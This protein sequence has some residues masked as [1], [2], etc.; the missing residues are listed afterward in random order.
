MC[1]GHQLASARRPGR[2]GALL[3]LLA[4]ASLALGAPAA[5]GEKVEEAIRSVFRDYRKAVLDGQGRRAAS[6]LSAETIDYYRRLQQQALFG[7][8]ETIRALPVIER[9]QVFF[10]RAHVPREDL[11]RMSGE[12]V[13][14]YAVGKGWVSQQQIARTDLGAVEIDGD[15]ALAEHRVEG[16]P[17]GV[18]YHF[19]RNPGD[20]SWRLDLLPLLLASND[21]MKHAAEQ[22][23]LEEEELVAE[24]L[25]TAGISPSDE[26]LWKPLF[27][28]SK[29]PVEP[30]ARPRAERP[31]EGPSPADE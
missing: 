25:R 23:E 31:A 29:A 8:E 1:S 6:L 28:D 5:R 10:F 20:G 4:A 17:S 12:E 9:V 19:V 3:G 18:K 27:P 26:T 30:G 13:V 14:A 11:V 16:E 21:L 2:R 22:A 24:L 7:R 15:S